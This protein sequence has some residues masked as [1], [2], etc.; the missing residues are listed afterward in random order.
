M[1]RNGVLIAG[2]SGMAASA[3]MQT[4]LGNATP[5]IVTEL[6]APQW[7]G[8]VG[9]SYL[10][11]ST[12]TLPIFAQWADRLGP[13]RIFAFG[14]LCF[15]VGALGVAI[16]PTMSW[17]LVARMVQGLG[18]GAIA[19]AAI[20]AIG[21][22]CQGRDRNRALAWLAL[23]QV[24]ANGL[25]AP[26]G[27]WFT[28]GPGWRI[29]M[30]AAAPLSLVSLLLAPTFPSRIAPK[31]WWHFDPRAQW[32]LWRQAGL[33]P[34]A[35]LACL[36]GVATV[37]V[38]TYAPLLLQQAHQL[39]AERAGWL[40]VPMLI[41]AGIGTALV[42]KLSSNRWFRPANWGLMTLGLALSLSPAVWLVVP[43]LTLTGVG[44]GATFPLLLFDAQTRVDQR[45]LAQASGLIQ[46]GRNAGGALGVPLLSLWLLTGPVSLIGLFLTLTATALAGLFLSRKV[47]S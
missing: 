11:L 3:L 36:V 28:D 26:L 8:F 20:A 22:V 23:T 5:R 7:Y 33:G 12:L 2:A 27:G 25:G 37:G 24:L 32:R 30:V 17:L 31:Q 42:G 41:G 14:H 44:M 13:R 45:Q 4:L 40:L 29:G 46:F 18:A 47:A 6:A 43:G 9:G 1:S 10:L 21:L 15:V 34:Q 16:A 39:S 19:P 38:T 35:L